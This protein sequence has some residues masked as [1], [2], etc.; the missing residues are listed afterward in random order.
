MKKNGFYILI[1]F[2]FVFA[3]C[4]DSNK[5]KVAMLVQK[6]QGREI[7]FPN[8][9]IFSQYAQDTLTYKIPKSEFKILLYV[10]STGCTG[11]KL[12]LYQWKE[13]IKE[14]NSLTKGKVPFIFIFQPK[15]TKEL[16]FLLRRDRINQPVCIDKSNNFQKKNKLPKHL[17]FNCF[18]LDKD[19]RIVCVGNPVYS[20]KVKDLYLSVITGKKKPELSKTTGT[21][22]T[23]KMLDMGKLKLGEK[24][25]II[26]TVK[27]TGNA[28]LF[29]RNITTSCGCTD[30]VYNKEPTLKNKKI[31]CSINYKAEEIGN[32]NRE[33]KVHYNGGNSPIVLHIKGTV[34]E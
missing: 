4:R 30:V 2:I 16:Q 14:V 18:L 24:R 10:D 26:F 8:D 19:N 25:S 17:M 5:D 7:I 29:I 27:N 32:F 23:P 31:Q 6:W 33:I 3:S 13:C 12:K 34:S 22:L 1:I 28:P 20:L 9:M 11:C 15:D 21:L